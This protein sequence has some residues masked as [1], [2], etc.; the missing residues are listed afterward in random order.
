MIEGSTQI[1]GSDMRTSPFFVGD[2]IPS[3][4]CVYFLSAGDKIKVGFSKNLRARFQSVQSS[5]PLDVFIIGWVPGDRALEKAILSLAAEHRVRG[6]WF[7]N[8]PDMMTLI[9]RV[10]SEGRSAFTGEIERQ[11]K[12]IDPSVAWAGAELRKLAGNRSPD[13]TIRT[14]VERAA[15]KIGASYWRTFDL[16]YGRAHQ[17]L[18]QEKDSIIAASAK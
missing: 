9:R 14:M 18:A 10:L 16:W 3:D 1:V 12:Q 7:V 13:D 6:E 15:T 8:C 11:A 2:V 4:P 5:S 17:L